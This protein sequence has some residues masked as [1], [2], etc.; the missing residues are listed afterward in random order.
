MKRSL[1]RASLGYT[2]SP[3]HCFDVCQLPALEVIIHLYPAALPFEDA[4]IATLYCDLQSYTSHRS[5]QP[6]IK[7]HKKRKRA[8]GLAYLAT[9]SYW[10]RS[11]PY[12]NS[13][14]IYT[15]I[16]AI[17][18][19]QDISSVRWRSLWLT[20][21]PAIHTRCSYSLVRLMRC[22]FGGPARGRVWDLDRLKWES[23]S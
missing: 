17:K 10:M 21:G 20:V 16:L 22:D 14:S 12:S 23:R 7:S 19:S 4:S 9:H 8:F 11:E 3:L 15:M 5:S 2:P 1:T 13:S 18:L 6:F